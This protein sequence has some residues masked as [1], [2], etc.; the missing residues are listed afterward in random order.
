MLKQTDPEIADLIQKE[1]DRQRDGIALISAENYTSKAVLEALGSVLTNKYSE[2]YPGKKYYGGNEYIDQI[3]IIAID[4]V[5]QL[6]GAQHANV[7]PHTGAAANIAA[8]KA[9]L[10]IGDVFMGLRLDQG[11]HLTHGSPVNFSGQWFRPVFYELDKETQQIDYD[12]MKKQALETKPKMIIAG[13]TIYPREVDFKAVREAAD[14]CGAYFMA[15][16]SHIAGLIAGKVHNNPAPYADIVTS[17][18][19]KTLRGPRSAFILCKKEHAAR[20]DKAVFPGLQGGPLDHSIAAKAVCFK[21]AMKPE[22]KEYAQQVVKN[23]KTLAS[24]LTEG[25]MS[26]VTGGTDTHTMF[27]DVT[28]LGVTGKEAQNLLESAGIYINMNMIPWDKRKPMDPSGVRIGTPQVTT[29]GM[30]ESEM[31]HIGEMILRV[32]KNKNDKQITE[33]VREEVKELCEQ[34]PIYADLKVE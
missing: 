19:H 23:A 1:I 7:Q 16:I 30:R 6:F 29:R 12:N 20:V 21:E 17:T 13:F 14:A 18:T 33:K 8:Y 28:S 15:D 10:E 11:G 5:K 4:R 25:G 9:F 32:M 22:F 34:F 24:V 27:G 31:E 3:E 2:G 26:L